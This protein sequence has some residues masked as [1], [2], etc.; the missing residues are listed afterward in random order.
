MIGHPRN[1]LAATTRV[2]VGRPHDAYAFLAALHNDRFRWR[3]DYSGSD[4]ESLLRDH[5][6]GLLVGQI[7]SDLYSMTDETFS[8]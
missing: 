4:R 3:N 5:R 1:R 6:R 8:M 2:A 7:P